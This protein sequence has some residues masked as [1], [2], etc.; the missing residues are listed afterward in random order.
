[1]RLIVILDLNAGFVQGLYNVRI[2]VNIGRL[3][4]DRIDSISFKQEDVSLEC[5][6][7]NQYFNMEIRMS[8][9][10]T[11][12]TDPGYIEI[13]YMELHSSQSDAVDDRNGQYLVTTAVKNGSL[14]LS[15]WEL[16]DFSATT[17]VSNSEKKLP[18]LCDQKT[19]EF[20]PKVSDK[21]SKWSQEAELAPAPPRLSVSLDGS[22]IALMSGDMKYFAKP[23]QVFAFRATAALSRIQVA[24]QRKDLVPIPDKEVNEELINFCGFG[25][26]HFLSTI[27]QDPKD[28]LFIT[29][30]GRNVD[31]Y[32]AHTKWRRRRRITLTVSVNKPIRDPW[33]LIEGLRGK[34]FS[35]SDETSKLLVCNL[36]TERIVYPMFLPE[37]TAYF[38]NDGKLM[39]C[40]EEHDTHDIMTTRWTESGTVLGKAKLSKS[41]SYQTFSAFIK[42][43]DHIIVPLIDCDDDRHP[44]GLGM[45]LDTTTLSTMEMVSFSTRYLMQQ[46]QAA[47]SQGHHIY[48]LHGSKL[49]MIRLHDIVIPPYPQPRYH[50]NEQCRNALVKLKKPDV[51]W[52]PSDVKKTISPPHSDLTITVQFRGST[53]GHAIE[54]SV[55]DSRGT[56]HETLEI[57]PCAMDGIHGSISDSKFCV[58]QASMQLIIFYPLCVMV[59]KLPR[60]VEEHVTLHKA[61]RRQRCEQTDKNTVSQV[62]DLAACR[63]GNICARFPNGSKVADVLNLCKGGIFGDDPDQFFHGLDMLIHMFE[64]GSDTF[65]PAVLRY[66]GRFINKTMRR[67]GHLETIFTTFCKRVMDK[68]VVL[69]DVFLKAALNSDHVRWAP[70]PDQCGKKNP[71]SILIKTSKS[72][73]RAIQLVRTIV[74]YCIRMA[75]KDKDP[76]FVS[77]VLES[78]HKLVALKELHP[79]LVLDTLR[80]L[81]HIPV[82]LREKSFVIDRA[83]IAYPPRL[84]Q[85][86][87]KSKS[88]PIYKCND[89]VLHLDRSPLFKKHDPQND[90]F[91]QDLFVASFDMLWKVPETSQDN[92]PIVTEDRSESSSTTIGT[93]FSILWLKMKIWSSTR[94]ECYD[95]PLES[96][97]NPAIAALIEYKWNTIGFIYWIVRFCFQCIFYLMVLIAVMIQVYDAGDART[98]LIGL[99]I[100]IIA[101]A[102]LFLWLE[103][104]QFLHNSS[105]YLASPYNYIDIA[106]FG[107]PLAGSV[108]QIVN[109]L[110]DNNHGNIS[111]LS[112]S[113]LFVALH[114]MFE[115]RVN[116]SV[117]HFVT[118]IIRTLAK[119]QVFFVIFA[120]GIVAFAIAILHLL[121]GS[122]VH[123]LDQ[124]Y[125][126]NNVTFPGDFYQ[127]IA[128][129]YFYMGGIWDSASEDFHNGN[130][131]FQTLMMLYFFFTT[132]LLLNLLIS[133]INVAFDDAAETWELVWMENKL[134]YIERAETITYNIPGYRESSSWFPNEIYYSATLQN[135]R[136]YETKYRKKGEDSIGDSTRYHGKFRKT[137]AMGVEFVKRGH[138]ELKELQK[139][140]H[141]EQK[142]NVEKMTKELKNELEK[143]TTD[144]KTVRAGHEELKQNIELIRKELKN[145]LKEELKQE[146]QQSQQ[147]LNNMLSQLKDQQHQLQIELERQRQEFKDQLAAIVGLL[148]IATGSSSGG[149]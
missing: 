120:A 142:Q 33:R 80:G 100:A 1:M 43:D 93:I 106:T 6:M 137:N 37:G 39:L 27:A 57:P 149:S 48:S 104:L 122:P 108:C 28:E 50:C 89:P 101:M 141:E 128:T 81:A 58:D 119:I 47:G 44:G 87:G 10:T 15:I 23:F 103:V 110:T 18:E 64:V 25:K 140:Q 17:N 139:S 31:I 32:S 111:V 109:I 97:N 132:I 82:P 70:G 61:W 40:R 67:D 83:I 66:T 63:H 131:A 135:R 95:L 36:E 69:Y 143:S 62:V 121:R 4:V 98:S 16:P 41:I 133:L 118:I 77:P 78:L 115:L 114:F 46:P 123:K 22:K 45:I 85:P 54:V 30:D 74:N 11:T 9:S 94:V 42:N 38:S 75:K 90:N 19:L 145:E 59:W 21:F 113:V 53:K 126:D 84:W 7:V 130:F 56:P 117:C 68:N 8:P 129:T 88:P 105:R 34:Y 136:G 71:I 92:C 147:N 79:D 125:L 102:S 5:T 144:H 73:P 2:A 26:F 49:D 72:V 29:C 91:T 148:H 96:L 3:N 138:E 112:F 116:K 52:S 13:H 24:S 99:F 65:K 55:V 76:H 35:W 134:R 12:K 127:A 60:T 20:L 14:Q 124:D 51:V 146:I 107:L 86:F